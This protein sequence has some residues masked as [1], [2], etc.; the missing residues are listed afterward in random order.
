MVIINKNGVEAH[1]Q[2]F[3][4]LKKRNSTDLVKADKRR[5]ANIVF[6]QEFNAFGCTVDVLN[7]NMIQRRAGGAH[8][9]VILFVNSSQVPLDKNRSLF[10]ALSA[11]TANMLL[12]KN[13]FNQFFAQNNFPSP[14]QL[15]SDVFFW[16]GGGC[17]WFP[18]I[19]NQ[20]YRLR[21]TVRKILGRHI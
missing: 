10:R 5:D 21:K 13:Q 11:V 17:N 1:Y 6:L 18:V 12:Y 3:K 14:L 19:G 4:P 7:N 20:V 8:C 15:K 16:G 2:N 9:H